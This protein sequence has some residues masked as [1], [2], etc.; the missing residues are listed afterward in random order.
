[1]ASGAE[2]SSNGSEIAECR[3]HSAKI[4]PELSSN[5]SN[6]RSAWFTPHKNPRRALM[7]WGAFSHLERSSTSSVTLSRAFTLSSQRLYLGFSVAFVCFCEVFCSTYYVA[8]L[9]PWYGRF[10]VTIAFTVHLVP[11]TFLEGRSKSTC[12]WF[13]WRTLFQVPG[14]VN[15]QL[16]VS[17]VPGFRCR[18]SRTFHLAGGR[19][20]QAVHGQFQ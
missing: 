19:R 8:A 20:S 5:G 18:G 1:M 6:V 2:S 12:W 14:S 10:D 15:C 4:R 9:Q 11:H 13:L 16:P 3:F 7:A 17:F